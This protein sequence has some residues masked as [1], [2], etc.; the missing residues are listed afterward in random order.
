[1]IFDLLQANKEVK[2]SEEAKNEDSK[3]KKK[4]VDKQSKK[5]EKYLIRGKNLL[6]F[7]EWDVW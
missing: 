3:K 2:A 1:M 7:N 4:V 6:K 5:A